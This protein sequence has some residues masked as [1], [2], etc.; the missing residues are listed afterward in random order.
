MGFKTQGKPRDKEKG[1]LAFQKANK[2]SVGPTNECMKDLGSWGSELLICV[3]GMNSPCKLLWSGVG[4]TK[5][6][7]KI[8]KPW[9]HKDELV[10]FK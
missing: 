10:D 8:H 7:T 6:I 9:N 1:L 2:L 4:T 3:Q 5:K